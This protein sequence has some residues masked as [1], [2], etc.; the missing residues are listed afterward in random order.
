MSSS[1][2][3][4]STYFH[5]KDGNRPFLMRRAFAEDAQTAHAAGMN[6]HLSKP[7]DFNKLKNILA[8]IK[9]NGS[10]SL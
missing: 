2:E 7:I 3:A 6:A 5:A 10:V 1:L 9:K 8:R 4:V